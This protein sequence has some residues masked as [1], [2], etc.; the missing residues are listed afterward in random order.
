MCDYNG[1]RMVVWSVGRSVGLSFRLV[2]LDWAASCFWLYFK[3]FDVLLM[4]GETLKY[5]AYKR[6][7]LTQEREVNCISLMKD[8][9]LLTQ[10]LGTTNMWDSDI[11]KACSVLSQPFDARLRHH[12]RT[13]NNNE[14][15][16]SFTFNDTRWI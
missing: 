1:L 13:K 6:C 8:Q 15:D 12:S 7:Y 14:K 5:G 9:L 16:A 3:S 4:E 2:L 11:Q 10:K